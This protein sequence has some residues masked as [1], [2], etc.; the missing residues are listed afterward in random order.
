MALF[1]PYRTLHLAR[2]GQITITAPHH[3]VFTGQMPF[4][5]PIHQRQSTGG[6]QMLLLDLYLLGYSYVGHT[7][8]RLLGQLLITLATT[9]ECD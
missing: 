4:L 3:S 7:D 2:P 1:G 9:D 6:K 8:L 5:L